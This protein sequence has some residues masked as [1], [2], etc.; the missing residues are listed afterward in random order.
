VFTNRV[1]RFRFQGPFPTAYEG[2]PGHIHLRVTAEAHK[3]LLLRV[4]PRP[5]AKQSSVRIVL[6]ADDL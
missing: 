3:Q 6:E 5:G 2:R 4:V 1:G